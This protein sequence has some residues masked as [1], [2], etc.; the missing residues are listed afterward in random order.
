MLHADKRAVEQNLRLSLLRIR[1]KELHFYTENCRSL[2]TQAALIASFAWFGLIMVILPPQANQMLKTAYLCMS[3]TAMGLELI[4][5]VNATLCLLLGPGL[6]L[7]G[8]D[9]SMHKA[10]DEMME[11]YRLVFFFFAIGLVAFNCAS[12]LFGYVMFPWQV[13]LAMTVILIIFLYGIQHYFLKIYGRFKI[14]PSLMITGRFDTD[15]AVYETTITAA[16]LRTANAEHLRTQTAAQRVHEYMHP[17]QYAREHLDAQR[18][19]SPPVQ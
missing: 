13:G 5:V 14:P 6:A 12:I 3:T 8:P 18:G 1:E 17:V 4:A 15:N 2:G 9:G 16:H 7:R 10:V 11:E 19:A